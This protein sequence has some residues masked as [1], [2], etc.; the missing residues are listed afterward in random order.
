[1]LLRVTPSELDYTERMTVVIEA[2]AD[3]GVTVQIEDYEQALAESGLAFELR[4]AE[5]SA[6]SPEEPSEDRRLWTNTYA[7]EFVLPG[8]YELPPATATIS[9]STAAD[10]SDEKSDVPTLL[11]TESIQVVARD[12]KGLLPSEEEQAEIQAL[13]PIELPGKWSRQWWWLLPVAIGLLAV[14]LMR[15]RLAAKWRRRREIL[16]ERAEYVP[17]HV[18]A[19]DQIDRLVAERL[20]EKGRWQT[21]HYRISYILRGYI[22]RRFRI[23]AGE[24]TTEEFLGSVVSDGRF[25]AAETE[26]L[27]HFLTTCDLVKYARHEPTDEDSQGAV[28][29]ARSYIDSTCDMDS[30]APPESEPSEHERERAA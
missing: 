23:L 29:A 22:E 1:M 25:G 4:V 28:E 27:Q 8:E 11:T 10:Q 3:P 2:T 5:S 26:Q 18:W 16:A 9:R 21:F 7:I 24:M 6:V 12:P 19:R 15:K 30:S 17:P 20:I 13:D 14:W